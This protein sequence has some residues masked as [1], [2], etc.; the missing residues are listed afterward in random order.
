MYYILITI[1]ILL[2]HSS[3]L[4]QANQGK[5]NKNV[6][7]FSMFEVF[8]K[9]FVVVDRGPQSHKQKIRNFFLLVCR[10]FPL[11][12]QVVLQP[13]ISWNISVVLFF[14]LLVNCWVLALFLN[15]HFTSPT[16]RCQFYLLCGSTEL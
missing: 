10:K 2:L 9:M 3:L 4:F 15:L 7:K 5:C 13:K 1:L 11:T 6:L 12:F 8:G 16:L 14:N